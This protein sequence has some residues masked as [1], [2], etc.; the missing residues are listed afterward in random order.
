M[1]IILGEGETVEILASTKEW[2]QVRWVS[3]QGEEV[4][5]WVLSQFLGKP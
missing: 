4:I 5:G 1:G 3:A 2:T